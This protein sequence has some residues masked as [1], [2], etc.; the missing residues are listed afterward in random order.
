M[1]CYRAGGCGPYEM[2]SCGECPAS[3]ESYLRRREKSIKELEDK[4]P[5][6][7]SAIPVEGMETHRVVEK[8]TGE[9]VARAF[10]TKDNKYRLSMV[11]NPDL[12]KPESI[13][14]ALVLSRDGINSFIDSLDDR[15]IV[16]KALNISC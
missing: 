12:I 9:V 8:E 11:N 6:L 1:N 10:L 15:Y 2:R 16:T 14:M 4:S 7:I 3:K 5:L 13:S